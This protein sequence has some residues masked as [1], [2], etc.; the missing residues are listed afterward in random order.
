MPLLEQHD[1][2]AYE[3]YLYSSVERPDAV[4]E[5]YRALAGNRFREIRRLDDV[6]AAELVRRDRIDILVNLALHGAGNRLR[7]FACKPAPVQMTWLGYA[8]TTGLDSIDYRITDP[9]FDPP[10]TDLGVYSET[11]IHLPES[12]WSYDALEADLPVGALPARAAGFV[13]FGCLNSYR[14]V[15][16]GLLALWARVLLE[17]PGARLMLFAEEHARKAVRQTLEAA[18]VQAERVEFVGRVSRREYLERYQRIDIALDTFPFAGGTTSLDAVWMGVPVVTLSGKTDPATR[19]RL[20]R[21]EPR[22][23]RARCEHGGGVR[24]QGGRARPRPRAAGP[25]ASRASSSARGVAVRRRAPLRAKP[26]GGVPHGLAA[27]L[28]GELTRYVQAPR[29]AAAAGTAID[30]DRV[31]SHRVGDGERRAVSAERIDDDSSTG[32]IEEK[33]AREA[34]CHDSHRLFRGLETRF[35][36]DVG[37]FARSW[38]ASGASETQ[39]VGIPCAPVRDG[40]RRFPANDLV[41][42]QPSTC[43]IGR[44]KHEVALFDPD[45]LAADIRLKEDRGG[46]RRNPVEHGLCRRDEPAPPR[47]E[48]ELVELR[49]IGQRRD[50]AH[51]V[52]RRVVREPCERFGA[53]HLATRRSRL[54]SFPHG[55]GH[56]TV[57]AR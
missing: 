49:K 5:Q 39:K 29:R 30:T 23:S 50:D 4:T 36:E 7:L 18:G 42:K 6:R 35:G 20:P 43:R 24:R 26:R 21:D 31:E 11:S 32:F 34:A 46:A 45:A 55:S 2:S 27:L 28:R 3:I 48:I 1:A 14:K 38:R 17:V 9:Y 54:R 33:L 51:L 47:V 40:A 22:A 12:F 41:P 19:G 57:N 37:T 10:G 8:G 13:T 15:H 52:V 16:P 53:V 56:R 44:P 25:V